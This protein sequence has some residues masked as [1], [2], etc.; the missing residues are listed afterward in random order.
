MLL[1]VF[2]SYGYGYYLSDSRPE[3]DYYTHPLAMAGGSGDRPPN[4]VY[5]RIMSFAE[6][7]K[8]GL[9]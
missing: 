2:F 9:W 5:L 7:I 3:N 6:P 8:I 4:G 1:Y